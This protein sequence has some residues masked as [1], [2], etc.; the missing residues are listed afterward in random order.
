M[1]DEQVIDPNTTPRSIDDIIAGLTSVGIEEFAEPILI[2]CQDRTIE[3]RL[4]NIPPE[5]E[6]FALMAVGDVKGHAWMQG[7]KLEILCRSISYI[8]GLNVKKLRQENTLLKSPYDGTLQQA[9]VLV[10]NLLD[11]WGQET[12]LLLWKV[13][14]VHA[15]SIENRLYDT[16]PSAAQMTD[17]E[18]RLFEEASEKITAEMDSLIKERTE[19]IID[20]VAAEGEG[21]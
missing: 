15:Q 7:V 20:A 14:M 17:V 5:A 12:I 8:D 1:A 16:L 6:R 21:S 3:I 10:R 2:P 18:R 9:H 4:E 13:L 11:H 19:E